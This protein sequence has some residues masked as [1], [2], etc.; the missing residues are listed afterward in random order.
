MREIDKWS[1]RFKYR[2]VSKI[3]IIICFFL[4]VAVIGLT[5]YGSNVGN[6][7][8]TIEEASIK[9]LSLA[10]NAE[11]NNPTSLLSAEGLRE[12]TNATYSQIPFDIDAYDGLHNDNIDY[13]YTAY[14]FY[15]RNVSEIAFGYSMKIE[16]T[17][18]YK[19]TDSAIRVMVIRNGVREIY[20]KWQEEGDEIGLPERNLNNDNISLY[21]VTNFV[22][23]TTVCNRDVDR[24]EKGATDKYTVVIWL[25]GW[26]PECIDD[27]KG[28]TVK[29][30]MKFATY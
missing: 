17:K 4:A 26:D 21:Q 3:V 2:K 28:G 11:F 5:Y 6:F 12:M 14:T 30:E 20:A 29:M 16:I 15:A 7:L 10:D 25:E 9:N 1:K 18:V 23:A 8:I 24:F 13:R 27:I 22:S 19:Q